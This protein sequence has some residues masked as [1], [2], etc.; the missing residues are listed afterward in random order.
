M[1]YLGLIS[2]SE[3]GNS[4]PTFTYL[5]TQQG[6]HKL[7]DPYFGTNKATLAHVDAIFWWVTFLFM[8]II[9]TLLRPCPSPEY[10]NVP[11]LFGE[12]LSVYESG[13]WSSHHHEWD[14]LQWVLIKP[15]EDLKDHIVF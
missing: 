13:G 9:M 15:F 5:S 1:P 3:K 14:S 12:V 2:E 6:Q 7:T 8:V 10:C 11:D 4:C